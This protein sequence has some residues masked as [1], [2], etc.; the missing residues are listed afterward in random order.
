[1]ACRRSGVRIP[2]AP[3]RREG[4]SAGYSRPSVTRADLTRADLTR[5]DFTR[6]DLTRADFTRADFTRADLTR[7]SRRSCSRPPLGA[8]QA[9]W[10]DRLLTGRGLG[11]GEVEL[12]LVQQGLLAEEDDERGG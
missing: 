4:R 2:L 12:L 1:M 3:H 8:E 5:A 7:R 11:V 10:S 6:A 9:E